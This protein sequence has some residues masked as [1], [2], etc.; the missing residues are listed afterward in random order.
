MVSEQ[1]DENTRTV[2]KSGDSLVVGFPKNW[3]SKLNISKGSE[4]NLSLM[5]GKHGIFMAVYPDEQKTLDDL[6][7]EL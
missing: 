6:Q 4:V 7:K 3:L 5:V 1:L 2:F